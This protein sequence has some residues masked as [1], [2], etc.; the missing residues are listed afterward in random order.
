[1]KEIYHTVLY[2]VL[3]KTAEKIFKF[4]HFL[5]YTIVNY[6]DEKAAPHYTPRLE[7]EAEERLIKQ[8]LLKAQN[9]AN[10]NN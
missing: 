9:K 8:E 6:L 2:L 1:M 3:S 5:E 7:H 4:S 10:E